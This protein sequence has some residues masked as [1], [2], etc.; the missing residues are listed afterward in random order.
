MAVGAVEAVSAG[1]GSLDA[2]TVVAAVNIQ[3]KVLNLASLT[4]PASGAGAFSFGIARATVLAVNVEAEVLGLASVALPASSASAGSVVA[5]STV[6]AVDVVAGASGL[7]GA[8][9]F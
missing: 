9:S 3:A 7:A 8:D 4:E 1:A 6:L 5:F 2:L